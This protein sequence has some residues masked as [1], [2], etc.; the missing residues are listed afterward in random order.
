MIKDTVVQLTI[1]CKAH[2]SV[3]VGTIHITSLTLS[4]AQELSTAVEVVWHDHCGEEC[5]GVNWDLF[6][7]QC[8]D[9]KVQLAACSCEV[10]V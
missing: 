10:M 4:L 6:P 8:E 5:P 1:F 7:D 9:A 2:K 3:S